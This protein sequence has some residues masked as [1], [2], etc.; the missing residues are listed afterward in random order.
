[1]V[2]FNAL[3]SIS[4]PGRNTLQEQRL[5]KQKSSSTQEGS[6]FANLMK[7]RKESGPATA[8]TSRRS[9]IESTASDSTS[10]I[11]RSVNPDAKE[12]NTDEVSTQISADQSLTPLQLLLSI[13]NSPGAVPSAPTPRSL[14]TDSD[15]AEQIDIPYVGKT[16]PNAT[17][18]IALLPPSTFTQAPDN[19]AA[20]ITLDDSPSEERTP[21][22]AKASS[23]ILTENPRAS[24]P[25]TTEVVMRE[26]VI[27]NGP[28]KDPTDVEPAQFPSAGTVTTT[29]NESLNA[30]QISREIKQYVGTS[31]WGEAVGKHVI[32]MVG[33]EQSSATLTLNP[34]ELGPLRIVVEVAEG[35]ANA[36]FSSENAHVRQMIEE[37]IPKLRDALNDAGITLSRADV[38]ARGNESPAQ[39]EQRRNPTQDYSP[40]NA[41]ERSTNV[42]AALQQPAIPERR[43]NPHRSG[44]VD[45]YA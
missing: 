42:A 11:H 33:A 36:R 35:Q 9:E 31:G 21:I 30:T 7:D 5:D 25:L 39:Q 40:G 45:F 6:R 22:A 10:G 34:P 26:N 32:W 15:N 44:L 3:P 4:V 43:A 23:A 16:D 20:K 8:A 24:S 2:N 14:Q 19:S 1:M 18:K 27:S 12:E 28:L 29:P 41:K 37:H 38:S 13:Q 17:G